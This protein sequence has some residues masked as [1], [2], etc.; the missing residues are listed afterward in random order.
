MEIPEV[1][2]KTCEELVQSY[3]DYEAVP[4]KWSDEA[5]EA[6]EAFC[7]KAQAAFGSV[8]V[9]I[10]ELISATVR[11]NPEEQAFPLAL[12][13]YRIAYHSPAI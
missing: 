3:I 8:W 12:M 13:V 5:E 1:D 6:H 11:L 4:D 2:F 7:D 10:V 9:P